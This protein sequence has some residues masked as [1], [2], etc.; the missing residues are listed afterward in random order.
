VIRQARVLIVDDSAFA[1]TVLRKL[2]R[3]HEIDVVGSAHDGAQALEL[4]ETLDPDVV[5]LD[6]TM[7]G[8]DGLGVLRALHGRARPRVLV[9]SVSTV[10]TEIG[11]EALSLGAIDIVAKPTA[12]A[13]DR[14]YEIGNELVA[15]VNAAA[16]GFLAEPQPAVPV[17]AARR[18]ERADLVMMGT[19]TGGPQALT[20]VLATLPADLRAP[21][22]MALHIPRGYTEG[23]ASRLDRMSPITVVE[24]TDGLELHGGLAALAPGGMHVRVVRAGSILKL[25]VSVLPLRQFAPSVDELFESG[26]VAV[27]PHALG[28]VLTGMGDD[29]LAGARA[30]VAAGGSLV[31]ES[32]A[33]CVV[34]GMPRCIVEAGL[35]ALPV[36]L[37]RIAEEIV[38][39]V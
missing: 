18:G 8:I 32:A 1:R 36:P 25:Q 15:K 35:G 34:Y 4:V 10:D 3:G 26:A 7:P 19:S 33:T 17:V 22:V 23:L 5:T 2:L 13:S 11:A 37:D 39:R 27:G 21:I 38:N 6:L 28:V 31:A 9:V 14:L 29:G 12:L 24:A 30:I 20:R 16:A